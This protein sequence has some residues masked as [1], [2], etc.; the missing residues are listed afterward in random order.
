MFFR[1]MTILGDWLLSWF[2]P[3]FIARRSGE[4]TSDPTPSNGCAEGRGMLSGVI[5]CFQLLTMPVHPALLFTN[6]TST[7]Q[8]GP[9]HERISSEQLIPKGPRWDV[10]DW[11]FLLNPVRRSSPPNR[12]ETGMND[13]ARAIIARFP[14]LGVAYR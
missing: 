13:P 6:R 10:V 2:S 5:D 8:S 1:V 11:M 9:L 7:Q 14:R 3:F 4:R 12:G